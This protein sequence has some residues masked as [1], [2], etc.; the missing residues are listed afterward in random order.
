MALEK[1][2]YLTKDKMYGYIYR[3][4]NLISGVVYIGQTTNYAIRSGNHI[5]LLRRGKHHNIRLQKDFTKYGE[6]YFVNEIIDEANDGCQLDV[7]ERFWID[8]YGGY[9]CNNVYNTAKGGDGSCAV[10]ASNSHARP[11]IH[12]DTMKLYMCAKDACEELGLNASG[13]SQC[14]H[15]ITKSTHDTHWCFADEYYDGILEDILSKPWFTEQT[16]QNM[17][18]NRGGE[19]NANAKRVYCVEI[20]KMFGCMK[21]ATMETG[22]SRK[23]IKRNCDWETSDVKGYHFMYEDEVT[24]ENIQKK[25]NYKKKRIYHGKSANV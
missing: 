15:K 4:T 21:D 20:D 2:N 19:L 23:A 7:L 12:L 24:E 8:A 13:I 5:R 17:R 22:V 10:G 16:I 6:Q 9:Q 3:I 18:D 1:C 25:L 14:C 11:V